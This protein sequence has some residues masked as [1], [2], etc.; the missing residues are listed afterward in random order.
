[1]VTY[2]MSCTFFLAF[3]FMI[4]EECPL[5][6]TVVWRWRGVKWKGKALVCKKAEKASQMFEREV[7]S[8]FTS[9]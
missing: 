1:M 3:N 9:V 2:A 8:E 6:E 7:W 5:I 4:Q